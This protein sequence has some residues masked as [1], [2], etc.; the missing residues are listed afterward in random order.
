MGVPSQIAS[1][2]EVAPGHDLARVVIAWAKLTPPLRAAILAIVEAGEPA[3]ASPQDERGRAA[4]TQDLE[5]IGGP[6]AGRQGGAQT[7]ERRA[8]PAG[9]GPSNSEPARSAD[10]RRG[11]QYLDAVAAARGADRVTVE[12]RPGVQPQSATAEPQTQPPR[13]AGSARSGG[14]EQYLDAPPVGPSSQRSLAGGQNGHA[15][16]H[17]LPHPFPHA[18]AT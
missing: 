14:G 1:Q 13:P 6:L 8:D 10:E 2:A 18:S 5:E 3:S 16:A 17:P 12:R 11:E 15:A 9:G 7:T 4:R